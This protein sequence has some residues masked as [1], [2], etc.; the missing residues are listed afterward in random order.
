MKIL[1]KIFRFTKNI[2]E[3][4]CMLCFKNFAWQDSQTEDNV[5]LRV[6]ATFEFTWHHSTK[7]GEGRH[8]SRAC[9]RSNVKWENKVPP[10]TSTPSSEHRNGRTFWTKAIDPFDSEIVFF[11]RFQ[12]HSWTGQFVISRSITARPDRPSLLIQDIDKKN[13]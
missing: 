7:I 13:S 11:T 1:N 12:Q 5:W 3:N 10:T 4:K 8:Q 9:P 2:F 6:C